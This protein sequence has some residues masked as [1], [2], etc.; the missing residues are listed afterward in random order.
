M[1]RSKLIARLFVVLQLSTFCACAAARPE[2]RCDPAPALIALAPASAVLPTA[3]AF[4]VAPAP[5]PAT[6]KLPDQVLRDPAERFA[7]TEQLRT[8]IVARTR[9]VPEARYWNELRPVLRRQIE[10]A[11][12][13]RPDVDFLLWEVDQ[14][15]PH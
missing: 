10:G 6:A 13:S 11:G 1:N 14:S 12:L 4:R 8:Q 2:G 9:R 15:R 5:A 7:L 3:P